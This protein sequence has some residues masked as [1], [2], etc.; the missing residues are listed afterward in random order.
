MSSEKNDVLCVGLLNELKRLSALL[1]KGDDD[2]VFN[3]E[4]NA[5]CYQKYHE[6]NRLE[7]SLDQYAGKRGALL[8]VGFLGHFSSGKS[9]TIVTLLQQSDLSYDRLTGLHPTDKA[10]TLITHPCN[11]GNLIGAHRRGE[12]AVGSSLVENDLLLE[13]VVVDTPGTGDPSVIEEMVRDFLPIC[14]RLIYIFSAAIPFDDTD[15]PILERA[16][17]ALPFIPMKFIVTRADEFRKDPLMA[18]SPENIDS[19]RVDV[20][21]SELIAR[22]SSAVTGLDVS[23]DDILIIDNITSHNAQKLA[24]FV[25]STD[26]YDRNATS[27]LHSHKIAYYFRSASEI[28]QFF[29]SYLKEKIS[30]LDLLLTTAQNNHISFQD[31]VTMANSRL[32]E[33]WTKQERALLQVQQDQADWVDK[34]D[35]KDDLP[36]SILE[37]DKVAQKQVALRDTISFWADSAATTVCNSMRSSLSGIL[38]SHV[39]S[40]HNNL[41]ASKDPDSESLT[42][43]VVEQPDHVNM[44]ESAMNVPRAVVSSVRQVSLEAIELIQ[45]HAAVIGESAKRLGDTVSEGRLVSTI[46]H[47]LEISISQLG[48]M[49]E[50]FLHSV[51]VY[52]SAI[53][54]VNAR[55]LAERAGIVSAIEQVERVQIS[56]EKKA[57]WIDVT[58]D[59]IL[60]NRKTSVKQCE[61]SLAKVLDNLLLVQKDARRLSNIEVPVPLQ[62]RIEES[63][64]LSQLDRDGKIFQ[65]IQEAI[66]GFNEACSEHFVVLNSEREKS[67]EEIREDLRQRLRSIRKSRL[68][69]LRR[70]T[71][72]GLIVGLLGYLA[73][74]FWKQPFQGNL[75]AIVLVGLAAN[76]LTSLMAWLLG[77]A[78]DKSETKTSEWKDTHSKASREITVR[79]LLAH[80]KLESWS[81]IDNLQ[82]KLK[83]EIASYWLS[84]SEDILKQNVTLPLEK[85]YEI[86]RATASGLEASK[87]EY[88][89]AASEL[90]SAL[91]ANYKRTSDNLDALKDVSA[92]IREQA[93]EPS[94]SLLQTRGKQLSDRLAELQSIELTP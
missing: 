23:P 4:K 3:I 94:F 50:D 57:L 38:S 77:R 36:S 71:F 67:L 34:L 26:E 13:K 37:A 53:L 5:S 74:H 70:Y 29:V 60:P 44:P 78:T 20:F 68:R 64:T 81:F 56:E 19:A 17:S 61:S 58:V 88:G 18:L 1:A 89:S 72:S 11:S 9:S 14:D 21:V 92:Q 41:V 62:I 16:K 54:A 85:H 73:F 45:R 25:L 32:T 42:P 40:L 75:A 84:E 15:I 69:R 8:Y 31:V 2:P 65:A 49:V 39:A 76:A 7:R 82:P 27:A 63:L 22:L 79:L 86:L 33:S 90:V 47:T 46:E 28:R 83:S 35:A 59:R 91:S 24:E 87:A 43:C 51:S 93:I 55:E 80:K 12:L 30:A 6:L 66:N 10:V 52:R 48:A